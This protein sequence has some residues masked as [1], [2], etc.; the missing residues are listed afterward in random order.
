MRLRFASLIAALVVLAGLLGAPA[1]SA[2]SANPGGGSGSAGGGQGTT[3]TT[4]PKSTTTTTTAPQTTTTAQPSGPV[5]G[6]GPPQT[7]PALPTVNPDDQ[8]I[9]DPIFNQGLL[10]DRLTVLVQQASPGLGTAEKAVTASKQKVAAASGARD[11]ATRAAKSADHRV[12]KARRRLRQS[13][14]AAYTNGQPDS[15]VNVLKGDPEPVYTHVTIGQARKA[16]AARRHDAHVA[17]QQRDRAAQA[18]AQAQHDQASA[19][20]AVKAQRDKIAELN[21]QLAQA[22][23]KL[24]KLAGDSQAVDATQAKRLLQAALKARGLSQ[25]GPAPPVDGRVLVAIQFALDQRGKP[26]RWGGNGPGAYD[27]SGLVQQSFIRA[28]VQ[29]PRVASSQQGATV[30]VSLS[31]ARPGDLVFFG[32]PATHVGLYLGNGIM[33][34][35]PYTGTVVRLDPVYRSSLSGF[36]RVIWPTG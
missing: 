26:Y 8:T 25:F 1:A 11:D 28:G 3:S 31:D 33:V 30:P 9:A 12:G 13:V 17:H 21:Q 5:P 24:A 7:A 27:C 19:E 36:G 35:A 15:G 23:Q 34:D 2:V 22:R 14:V 4:R 20:Q 29:L 18:L 10:V 32:Y 16:L 6:A